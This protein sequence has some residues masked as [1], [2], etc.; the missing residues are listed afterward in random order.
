M[1]SVKLKREVLRSFKRLHRAR[2]SVFS[3]DEH[4]LQAARHKINCE[5]H[6]NKQVTDIATVK[7]LVVF[8][9]SVEAELRSTVIQAREVKP[10]TF[11]L[12]I[13]PD[14]KKLDNV[15]GMESKP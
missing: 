12:R 10:G 9:K 2:Q 6:K 3:G 14:I 1:I 4:A 13:T 7:E 8:S 15:P 5:Y 11:A